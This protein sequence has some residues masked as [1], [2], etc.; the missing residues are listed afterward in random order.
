MTELATAYG[1]IANKGR[2]IDLD[3]IL[4]IKDSGGNIIYSKNPVGAQV[5]N[6]GNAFILS[7]ILA[8][9]KART[10]EFGPNSALNITE[11][12]VSVKTGTTDVKRDNW[13]VGFTPKFL[14]A[15]W[16][17][18]NDN[19]PMNQALASGITGAA[20][21]WNKLTHMML[22]KTGTPSAFTVPD[23]V[24]K[25]YCNGQD[26]YFVKGTE[27]SISCSFKPATSGTPSPSPAQ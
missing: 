13:T 22:D 9:N 12:K 3:P 11:A 27:K 8:D 10:L 14:I 6:P 26:R 5:V 20:P 2:R 21:M 18:N 25:K 19:T 7:D 1:T 24:I 23:N 17:G 16:V 15:T 4:E